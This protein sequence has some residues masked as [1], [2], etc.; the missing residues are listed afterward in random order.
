MP[1][2]LQDDIDFVAYLKSTDHK[3]KVKPAADFVPDAKARL[4]SRK[5]MKRTFLPWPKCNESFEFRR[6]E[7]TI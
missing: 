4:R 7:V 6:G 3:T 5:D 1:E 2:Y